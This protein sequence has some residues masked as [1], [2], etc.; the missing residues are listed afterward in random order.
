MKNSDIPN[1]NATREL[2]RKH[3]TAP[4]LP[5]PDFVN[6]RV[7]EEIER[8]G[9]GR[10]TAP[11]PSLWRLAWSGV[12]LLVIA[13]VLAAVV[14]PTQ[15][16]FRTEHEFISQV[17]SARAEAPDCSITQFQAPE[18]GVVIWVDGAEYI[19]GEQSVQ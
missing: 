6:S 1:W 13:G 19:P 4:D 18:R 17:I 14:L 10:S 3:L 9:R 12:A 8:L 2:L 11:L 16:A 5:H 7:L 15:F